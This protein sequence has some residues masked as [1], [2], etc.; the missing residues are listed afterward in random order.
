MTVMVRDIN[1]NRPQF[2]RT[3][4]VGSVPS[5]LPQGSPVFR[6]SAVDL[7][8]GDKIYYR[9]VS[10]NEDG[11]F[12]LDSSSGTLTAMCDLRTLA[13]RSRTIN[14]TA[15]DGQHFSD[16]TSVTIRIEDRGR[17]VM[18]DFSDF[19]FKCVET[20]VAQHLAD[21]IRLAAKNNVMLDDQ[22]PP[23]RFQG[24]TNVHRPEFDGKF[25]RQLKVSEAASVGSLLMTVRQIFL[26][27][28]EIPSG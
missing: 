7:D 4:C 13:F 6:L 18:S 28:F 14:V 12:S 8:S 27:I 10:G 1:D 2:E 26:C 16:V 20:N 24:M 25:P 22:T 19:D 17:A 9:T 21:T 3:A 5:T 15:T 11:C 23:S